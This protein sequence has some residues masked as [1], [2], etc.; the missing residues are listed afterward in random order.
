ME[1]IMPWYHT[2]AFDQRVEFITQW[3]NT[4]QPLKHLCLEYGISRKT[5]YKWISRFNQEGYAGL[6]DHS[7]RPI[8]CPHA[9]QSQTI[10]T[11]LELKCAFPFWGP[12]TIK[13]Y[14]QQE[15]P[16]QT[17]PAA[18]TIGAILKTHGLVKQRKKR[19][20]VPPYTQPF[21]QCLAP[22]DTWSADFKGHFKVNGQYC[23]P[24][25]VIDNYSRKLLACQALT[26]T[27]SNPV[28]A[29]FKKLF[30]TYGLP[31]N[32]RT[33]NGYPFASTNLGG[34]SHLSVFWL[35][36]G[37]NPERIDKGHP[38]QNGRHERMHR[39]LKQATA[40]PPQNSMA[41][42]QRV[43]NHFINE[44]NT[45]RPHHGIDGKRPDDLYQ[46]SGRHFIAHSKLC[47]PKHFLTRYVKH[48]GEISFKGRMIYIAQ[49]LAKENVGID[50]INENQFSI[51][52]AHKPIAI[53]DKSIRKLIRI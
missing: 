51:Y 36:L 16:Q 30:I 27:A 32:I 18:S 9:T 1:S 46:P 22:N 8:H 25:T 23:Y 21:A 26:S 52:F 4:N 37:I 3:R 15:Y 7:C 47:Y 39:T 35:K 5:A 34:L 43:F 12:A 29:I 44:Y 45:V 13:L 48:N 19:K 41:K 33:D 2:N 6:Q 10:D 50:I 31:K 17:W 49:C 11:I 53:Y 42:Q 24:L 28:Q 38:E 40:M 14:L 20:H